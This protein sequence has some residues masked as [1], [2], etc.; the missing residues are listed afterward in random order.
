MKDE[1]TQRM[2]ALVKAEAKLHL[3]GELIRDA[4]R[5]IDD[6]PFT[7]GWDDFV[8]HLAGVPTDL[9]TISSAVHLECLKIENG[10]DRHSMSP[11]VQYH[12]P[13]YRLTPTEAVIDN[14]QGGINADHPDIAKP[15]F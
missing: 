12:R 10:K 13:I 8:Q 5:H 2:Q 9:F 14:L 11:P 7:P 4:I 1:N 3:A 6:A 15:G